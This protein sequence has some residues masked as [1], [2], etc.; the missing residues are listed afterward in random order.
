MQH[1]AQASGSPTCPDCCVQAAMCPTHVGKAQQGDWRACYAD[2]SP[3]AINK[4][5]AAFADEK[6]P[7][8][9]FLKE[10]VSKSCTI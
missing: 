9:L 3:I 10:K 8:K 4:R 2:D 6:G 7:W 1:Q 5:I